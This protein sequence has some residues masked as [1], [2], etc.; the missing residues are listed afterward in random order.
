MDDKGNMGIILGDNRNMEVIMGDK[1]NMGIILGDNRNMEV[2][3]GDKGII[4][5]Y[6]SH[7]G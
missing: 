1:G 6:G 7:N 2:I 3:I 4:A 5:Q